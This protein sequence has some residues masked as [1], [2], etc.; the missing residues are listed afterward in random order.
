MALV[1][2]VKIF[3]LIESLRVDSIHMQHSL[4]ITNLGQLKCSN[5]TIYYC[6][7]RIFHNL[8]NEATCMEVRYLGFEASPGYKTE[9]F[10]TVQFRLCQVVAKIGSNPDKTDY[11]QYYD[12]HHTAL[13][14]CWGDEWSAPREP[15]IE[16]DLFC[17]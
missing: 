16:C 7:N 6:G 15:L 8:F 9:H 12:R 5:N 2:A 1:P 3:Y 13:W 14:I 11:I 4:K 17:T 10:S